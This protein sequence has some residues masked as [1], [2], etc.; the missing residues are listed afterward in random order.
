[1]IRDGCIWHAHITPACWVS[2]SIQV[3][4]RAVPYRSTFVAAVLP[5]GSAGDAAAGEKVVGEDIEAF[6]REFPTLLARVHE[7]LVR[8]DAMRC[9]ALRRGEAVI[10]SAAPA[11][12]RFLRQPLHCVSRRTRTG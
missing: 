10:W 6:G 12:G 9:I 2:S 7:F 11:R 5:E 3:V 1:M 4:M 8:C